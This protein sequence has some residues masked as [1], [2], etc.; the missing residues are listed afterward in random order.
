VRRVGEGRRRKEEAKGSQ[1]AH[2]V[3]FSLGVVGSCVHH[4]NFQHQQERAKL[5]FYNIDLVSKSPKPFSK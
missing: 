1:P 2:F 5:L 3:Y 4:F